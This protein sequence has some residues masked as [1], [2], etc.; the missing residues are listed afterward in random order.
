MI[1]II[2]D[3]VP[4]GATPMPDRANPRDIAESLRWRSIMSMQSVWLWTGQA[5][6][7]AD[8][9]EEMAADNIE[10]KHA[11]EAIARGDGEPKDIARNV[12]R[13]VADGERLRADR[14][15]MGEAGQLQENAAAVGLG[16]WWEFVGR[17]FRKARENA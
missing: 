5:E 1:E 14:V 4:S 15:A 9:I 11:L 16:A 6:R 3:R 8:F 10:Y 13:D 7:S 2:D 17:P 12:L